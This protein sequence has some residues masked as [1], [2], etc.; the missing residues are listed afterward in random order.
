VAAESTTVTF[1]KT[2][3]KY[4][5]APPHSHHVT[6]AE[7]K[8][9]SRDLARAVEAEGF[10]PDLV[11]GLSNGAIFPT[12]VVAAELGLPCHMV[13]VRRRG[14]RYKQRLLIVQK[15]LRI[16]SGLIMWGPIKR[17]WVVFQNRT[18]SLESVTETFNIDVAGRRTLIVDDCVDTGASL[19]YVAER[20]RAGGAADI[21][22]AVYCWSRM[23]HVDEAISRPDVYLHRQTQYYP[24]SNNSRYLKDFT[25][26]LKRN[27][28]TLWT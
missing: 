5:S 12:K 23:P 28:L 18:N 27:G 26:W 19:R 24:W 17:L 7:A 13:Q 20:L 11:V 2:Y 9:L 15:R 14:S 6:L 21:M 8:D 16:P 25:A 4:L 1:S 3:A 22:T 10:R